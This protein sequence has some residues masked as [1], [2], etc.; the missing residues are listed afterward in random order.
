MAVTVSERI[1]WSDMDTAGIMYFGTYVRLFEI[2]ETELFRELGIPY[3][4]DV[5]ERMG[6]YFL[7]RNFHCDFL[8][9][10]RLDDIV[11]I[12]IG[13]SEIRSRAARMDF[14]IDCNG[15]RSGT[16]YCTIVAV[17]KQSRTSIS[18]PEEIRAAMQQYS[19]SPVQS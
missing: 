14:T 12:S 9:P 11:H 19:V 10:V 7:R 16:G 18:I 4:D 13:F 1:R 2:G 8:R 5:M 6:F 3:R 17:D 15:T